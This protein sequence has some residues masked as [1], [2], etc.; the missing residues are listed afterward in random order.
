L[1]SF[2]KLYTVIKSL[3]WWETA[4]FRL[5]ILVLAIGV[6]IG[7][8][9]WRVSAIEAR[10]RELEIRVVERTDELA[11]SNEQLK[12]AKE[13]ALEAKEAALEAQHMAEAANQA[14]STFLASMSHEL[15]TPLNAILGFA[16]LME[17]DPQLRATQCEH[18]GI[19]R[20]SG[21]HLLKL[22]NDVLDM[23]RIEAGQITLNPQSFDFY[24][25]LASIEEMVRVRAEAKDLEFTVIR[26][27]DVPQYIK[28][29][30]AKLR[31]VLINL[32]SNA[33]KFTEEG[34]VVLR[35][36]NCELRNEPTPHPSQEG[37]FEI[38]NLKFEIE[39]TGIGIA[40]DEIETIFDA[41]KRTQHSETTKEGTGLG[42][43]I[44]RK[45][46]RLMGGDITVKSKVGKGTT[47]I[48][49]I[50]VGLVD[51]STIDNRQSTIDNPKP[52]HWAGTESARCRWRAVS[53]SG[54]GGSS[55]K[56]DAFDPV[57]QN[58]RL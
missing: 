11:Q 55:G 57:A 41:F 42:L 43:A 19:I 44:S 22:I 30:E 51:Q 58:S 47:F 38:R 2:V 29:D 28:T 6:L 49:E 5:S 17:R 18:L 45:F 13:N 56:S 15:R 53:Y 9:R 39:D 34:G 33:V 35:I 40:P 48:F 27:Q 52:C 50:R 4:W 24:R 16:Q 14:K 7:G 8:Y 25:T 10:S 21:E 23:S 54:G 26:G 36:A 20:R 1:Y 3:P 37:K 12:V 46:V 31:Q 32:L